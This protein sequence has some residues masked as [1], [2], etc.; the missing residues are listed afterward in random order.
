MIRLANRFNGSWDVMHL[1][2]D[3]KEGWIGDNKRKN[4]KSLDNA[5]ACMERL[6][7]R[8]KKAGGR[9]TSYAFENFGY[10]IKQNGNEWDDRRHSSKQT[11]RAI[12]NRKLK[13]Q[14]WQ[15]YTNY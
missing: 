1:V 7:L 5:I 11:P 10:Q 9:V 15:K 13:G 2:S 12:I 3:R 4:F 8:V 14:Y 6:K